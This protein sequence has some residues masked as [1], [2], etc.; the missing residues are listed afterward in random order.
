MAENTLPVLFIHHPFARIASAIGLYFDTVAMIL[1]IAPV[2]NIDGAIFVKHAAAPIFLPVDNV[3]F[4]DVTLIPDFY[5]STMLYFCSHFP[6][7]EIPSI[8]LVESGH[9]ALLSLTDR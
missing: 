3:A 7:T 4:V 1:I 5:A 6:L 2:T 8:E 9:W